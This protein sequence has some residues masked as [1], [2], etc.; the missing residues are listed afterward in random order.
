MTP[1]TRKYL[2]FYHATTWENYVSIAVEGLLLSACDPSSKRKALWV[3]SAGKVP[4]AILHTQ[5]RHYAPLSNIVV[6]D[7]VL[8]RSLVTSHGNG[9][10]YVTQD[11]SLNHIKGIRMAFDIATSTP[12]GA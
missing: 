5:A 1:L 7:I 2:H 3:C 8:E 10:W 12:V 6:L 4:W 9:L 11:I